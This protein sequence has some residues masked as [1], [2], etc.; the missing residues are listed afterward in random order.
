[1]RAREADYQGA[2][3]A[4]SLGFGSRPALVV[5]DLMVAYFDPDSPMYARSSR[6]STRVFA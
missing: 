5:V 4:G 1:M 6:F 3:F 2:G